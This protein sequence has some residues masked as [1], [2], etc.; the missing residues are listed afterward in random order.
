MK[1]ELTKKDEIML[2]GRD[3]NNTRDL[4]ISLQQKLEQTPEYIELQKIKQNYE[5]KVAAYNELLSTVE[6]NMKENNLTYLECG[7]FEFTLTTTKT[8]PSVVIKDGA[9]IPEQYL[10]IKSEPNKI[11]LKKALEDGIIIE[12]IELIQ[13]TK[14]VFEHRRKAIGVKID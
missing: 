11:D 13:G 7:D 14:E 1:Y 10:R 4:I 8:K 5:N 12:G 6:S 9:I 3:I 2:N